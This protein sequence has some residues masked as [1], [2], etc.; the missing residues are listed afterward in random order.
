M[1]SEGIVFEDI[2]REMRELMV[3]LTPSG[4]HIFTRLG[5]QN[6]HPIMIGTC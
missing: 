4:V 1:P 3:I 2:N 5:V 6:F